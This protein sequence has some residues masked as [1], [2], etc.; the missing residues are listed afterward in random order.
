MVILAVEVVVVL[1]EIV[2]VDVVV[3]VVEGDDR[4]CDIGSR[5]GCSARRGVCS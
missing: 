1:E 5:G 3:D 4:S 2:V